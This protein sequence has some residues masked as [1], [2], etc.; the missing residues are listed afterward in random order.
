MSEPAQQAWQVMFTDSK[1]ITRELVGLR[2]VNGPSEVTLEVN[3]SHGIVIGERRFASAEAARTFAHAEAAQLSAMVAAGSKPLAVIA[4]SR[5]MVGASALPQ[6]PKAP[7]PPVGL[8]VIA[9][10]AMVRVT[11]PDGSLIAERE[12]AS[13]YGAEP[14]A[15]NTAKALRFLWKNGRTK[16][17]VFARLQDW[18]AK[19]AP[20]RDDL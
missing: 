11:L 2:L 9:V 8:R 4:A 12:Y 20:L 15:Q 19:I 7:P 10:G 1:G 13:I 14:G 18:A 6:K 16:E 3:D 17:E 5:L